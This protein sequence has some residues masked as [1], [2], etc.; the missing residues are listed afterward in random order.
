MINNFIKAVLSILGLHK[1]VLYQLLHVGYLLFVL[2]P[3]T[4]QDQEATITF[5]NLKKTPNLSLG[6]YIQGGPK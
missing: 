3:Y 6:L 5:S 1:H 2:I 4:N